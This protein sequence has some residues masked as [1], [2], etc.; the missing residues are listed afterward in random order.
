MQVESDERDRHIHRQC[1]SSLLMC[2][3]KVR[4]IMDWNLEEEKPNRNLL[5]AESRAWETE[6]WGRYIN[7]EWKGIPC[8]KSKETLFEEEVGKCQ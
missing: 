2:R 8:L 6:L 4:I 5:T 1:N 7:R 3:C